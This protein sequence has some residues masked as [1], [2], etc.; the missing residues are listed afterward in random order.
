MA[1]LHGW[2]TAYLMTV[3][4]RILGTAPSRNRGENA[5]L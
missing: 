1:T 2:T 4:R 3:K 5:H